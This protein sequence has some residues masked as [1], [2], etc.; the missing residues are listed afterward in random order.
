MKHLFYA[1]FIPLV[2]GLSGCSGSEDEP[3]SL[4]ADDL[5]TEKRVVTPAPATP[6]TPIVASSNFT[7]QVLASELLLIQFDQPI[8]VFNLSYNKQLGE[9]TGDIQ[10][11]DDQFSTCHALYF[12]TAGTQKLELQVAGFKG[13]TAYQLKIKSGVQS[14]FGGKLEQDYISEFVTLES[15][16]L[17]ITEVG[18]APYIDGQ[19]WLE[20][21]NNTNYQINLNTYKLVS[22]ASHGTCTKNVGCNF[23]P[24]SETYSFALSD[25]IIEPGQYHIIK[26]H[27][28]YSSAVGSSEVSYVGDLSTH[29]YWGDK[30]FLDL[31]ILASNETE[32][33]V[34]FGDWS[35]SSQVP[36]P[37]ASQEWL[38]ETAIGLPYTGTNSDYGHSISRSEILRDSNQKLDWSLVN[39]QT[40]GGP[41][42]VNCNL[43]DTDFDGLPDC[44]E[45][46]GATYAGIDLYSLGA[47]EFQTDIFVELDYMSGA[48]E[49]VTPR[50]EALQKIVD[51]FA[52]RDIAVHFDVGDLFD[53]APGINPAKFDLGGGNLVPSTTAVGF[54]PTVGGIDNFY[55]IKRQHIDYARNSIFHYM[56]MANSQNADGSGGSGG[57]AEVNANDSII[58]LGG[59]GLN[60][61]TSTKVNELINVQA[62]TIMHELGHNLG[63]LHGGDEN[64]NNK[65]NYLSVM[66]YLYAVAGLPEIGDIDEGDRYELEYCT[67]TVN[68]L[69]NSPFDS[70]EDFILDY[71][72]GSAVG[73]DESSVNESLGLGMTNSDEVDY[74]CD[75]FWDGNTYELDLNRDA[76]IDVLADHDD[77]SNLNLK[78]Q[79][80]F[81]SNENFVERNPQE[82]DDGF[83]LVENVIGNDR[84][85]I[86]IEGE[87]QRGVKH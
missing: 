43:S 64:K 60:S 32:D 72:Y 24:M 33:F 44:A 10:L 67:G 42:D 29:M 6:V 19:H 38:G 17:L 5:I 3:T 8:D 68:G 66:N 18:A 36:A 76:T 34:L 37:T 23:Q 20:V 85:D 73:L 57:I 41:N 28:W 82:H 40:P 30:G 84:A 75:L 81:S 70:Y 87:I 55:D 25:Q 49:G 77:W 13:N 53:Q 16:G 58:T 7:G 86:I 48:D 63:L 51:V 62:S 14:L 78:F 79:H 2:L 45:R 39:F 83:N 74:N 12:F 31:R 56:L 52:A 80:S 15:A 26:S 46:Q 50:V 21:Y 59:W 47:R 69:T 54:D 1:C 61:A 27:G 22:Q 4:T 11:S 35:S 71:S 9:C 65:P